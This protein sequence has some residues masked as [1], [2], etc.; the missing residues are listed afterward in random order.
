MDGT[1]PFFVQLNSKQLRKVQ[2]KVERDALAVE[3]V[4]QDDAF[5]PQDV[6]SGWDNPPELY[7]QAMMFD[8]MAALAGGMADLLVQPPNHGLLSAKPHCLHIDIRLPKES[9]AK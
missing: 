9:G 8:P 3:L 1:V 6:E 4:L 2:R 7:V 5:D